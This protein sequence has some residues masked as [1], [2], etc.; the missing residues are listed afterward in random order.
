MSSNQ[1]G[2]KV[3]IQNAWK[4]KLSMPF[5]SDWIKVTPCQG[6]HVKVETSRRT[7][8]QRNSPFFTKYLHE[9]KL[10]NIWHRHDL[11]S[12]KNQCRRCIRSQN[13]QEGCMRLLLNYLHS[14]IANYTNYSNWSQPQGQYWS[15]LLVWHLSD[16]VELRLNP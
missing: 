4:N 7:H 9:V 3:L 5:I 16:H 8:Y 6:K 2:D 13:K 11:R 12:Q 1:A 14:G 15:N 10:A